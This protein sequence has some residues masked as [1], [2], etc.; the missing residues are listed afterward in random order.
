MSSVA[1]VYGQALYD[2]AR[3]EDCA[4]GVL[5]E[6]K[7]LALA[8]TDEPDFVRLV[9]TPGLPKAERLQIL[10]D[11]FRDRVHPYVLNFMKI[12]TEKGYMHSFCE[13]ADVYQ[14]AYNED[15]NILPV[16]VTSAQ[17]LTSEQ[18]SRLRRKLSSL[19]GKQIEL[20]GRIDPACIGGLRLD[21]D[22]KQV[23]D[24]IS[25]RLDRLHSMLKNTAL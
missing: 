3:D 17:P 20:I 23:D 13:C 14:K 4:G 7:T 18:E 16:K 25:G 22:G 5:H 9:S 2:L 11:S 6:M 15:H 12:L 19:T 24:T 10:D 1:S 21:Y 8:F